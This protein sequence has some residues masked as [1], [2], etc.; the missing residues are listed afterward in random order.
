MG[1][2]KLD[3]SGMVS[4]KELAGQDI[5]SAERTGAQKRRVGPVR[6]PLE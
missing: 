2:D 3:R 5:R 4:K 1:H 6:D